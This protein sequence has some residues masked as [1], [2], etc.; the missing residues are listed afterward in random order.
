MPR[1]L[2]HTVLLLAVLAG[3]CKSVP[4]ISRDGVPVSIDADEIP[5][6]IQEAELALVEDRP[7]QALNWMRAANE[8]EGM[9]TSEKERVQSLT[10]K[11]ADRLIKAEAHENGNTDLLLELLD[12]NLPRQIAVSAGMRAAELQVDRGELKSAYKTIRKVDK[13]YPTHH[14]RST[15]AALLAELGIRLSYD[16][17]GFLFFTDNSDDGMAALEYF[18]MNYPAR[19]RGD[20]A[21]RRLADMYEEQEKWALAIERHEELILEHPD[22]VLVPESKALVPHLRLRAVTSPEYDRGAVFQA[23]RE[24]E[25]WLRDHSGH[26]FEDFVRADLADARRRLSESDLGIARFYAKIDN[27]WGARHHAARALEEA[28]AAGDRERIA[29]AE[30]ILEAHGGGVAAR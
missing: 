5:R 11:A 8:V 3:G 4:L 19:P 16:E 24:L 2:R 22:S 14:E 26:P 13:L 17:G 29:E 18:V 1:R 30:R 23:R 27:D 12:M 20:E 6:A 15:A 25:D 9:S 21:Y 28:R 10:E 7:M